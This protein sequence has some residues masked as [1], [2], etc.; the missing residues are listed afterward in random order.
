MG[1]EQYKKIL[2]L[3]L[4]LEKKIVSKNIEV[5]ADFTRELQKVAKPEEEEFVHEKF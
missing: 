5:R 1:E 4:E 2:Q 3:M